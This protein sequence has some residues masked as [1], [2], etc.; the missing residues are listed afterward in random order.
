MGE[1]KKKENKPNKHAALTGSEAPFPSLSRMFSMDATFN[2]AK[3]VYAQSVTYKWKILLLMLR[4]KKAVEKDPGRRWKR[5]YWWLMHMEGRHL[6]SLWGHLGS[7]RQLCF[8]HKIYYL[9]EGD[10]VDRQ[11][12]PRES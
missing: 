12:R 6:A 3:S 11:G 7:A 10:K 9:A 4:L 2:V 1:K 5:N 8:N